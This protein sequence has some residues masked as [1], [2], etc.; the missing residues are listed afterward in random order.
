MI[1]GIIS[2]KKIFNIAEKEKDNLINNVIKKYISLE[3]GNIF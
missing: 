3:N 2:I 1:N